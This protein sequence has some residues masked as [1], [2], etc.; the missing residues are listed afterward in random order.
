MLNIH[1][2]YAYNDFVPTVYNVIKAKSPTVSSIDPQPSASHSLKRRDPAG[3]KY[4]VSEGRE[5]RLSL[6]L[7]RTPCTGVG[8]SANGWKR[9]IAVVQILSWSAKECF[10]S[11]SSILLCLAAVVEHTCCLFYALCRLLIA[12]NISSMLLS[13]WCPERRREKMTIPQK[14][15]Y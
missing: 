1:S 11:K 2:K 14:V 3:V 4:R 6:P 8:V 13:V 12:H 10:S 7:W 9:Y 15:C 5:R